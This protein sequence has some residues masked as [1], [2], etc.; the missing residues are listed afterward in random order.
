MLNESLR[1]RRQE[2][3]RMRRKRRRAIMKKITLCKGRIRMRQGDHYQKEREADFMSA[4][5]NLMFK[6]QLRKAAE[7]KARH[8]HQDK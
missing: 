2:R 5:L 4:I 7:Q 1:H 6:S 8:T 3:L